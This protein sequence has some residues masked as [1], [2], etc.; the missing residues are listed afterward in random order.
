MFTVLKT[1][2]Q[3]SELHCK[4]NMFI[5]PIDLISFLLSNF[6][7]NEQGCER[8]ICSKEIWSTYMYH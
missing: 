7:F 6:K 4:I 2:K 8:E 1:G 3:L 5:S